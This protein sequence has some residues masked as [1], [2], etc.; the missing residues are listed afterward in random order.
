MYGFRERESFA[1]GPARRSASGCLAVPAMSQSGTLSTI[2]RL[3]PPKRPSPV[4]MLSTNSRRV[5]ARWG[6]ESRFRRRH[7][8]SL[9]LTCYSPH[10]NQIG[11]SQP[12]CSAGAAQLALIVWA[13]PL[14][15]TRM[16]SRDPSAGGALPAPPLPCIERHTTLNSAPC[17]PLQERKPQSES[18]S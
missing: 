17:L 18:R 3:S 11:R 4:S 1:P 9:G 6:R 10:L 5:H 12:A 15:S 16:T 8:R 13:G 7:S 2:S 14:S